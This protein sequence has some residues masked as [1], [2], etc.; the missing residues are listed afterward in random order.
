MARSRARERGI[1]ASFAHREDS[2]RYVI[3][4]WPVTDLYSWDCPS[5]R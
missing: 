3:A 2:G 5:W 4:T 1:I